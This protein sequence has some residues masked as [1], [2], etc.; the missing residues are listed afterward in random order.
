MLR[1]F[2]N[3]D[4]RINAVIQLKSGKLEIKYHDD[5]NL[6]VKLYINNFRGINLYLTQ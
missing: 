2:L 1:F 5:I 3:I 4:K 6:H